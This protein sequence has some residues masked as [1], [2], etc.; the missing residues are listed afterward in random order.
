[1]SATAFLRSDQ[2][3][4]SIGRRIEQ[5][6][7]ERPGRAWWLALAASLGLVGVLVASL[8]WLLFEGVGVWNNNIPVTW[9]LDIVGYDWWIGIAT[10]ALSLSV[11]P[12]LL[13]RP[14]RGAI[15]RTS[16][17]V[18]VL[19]ALAAA[20]YPVVHLGRPWFFYWNLPY[21]NT[22]LLWP[23]F[24]SPLFWD[25]TDIL[26]YLAVS[27]SLWYVGLLP[28][29]AGLRDRAVDR[30]NDDT[31]G[32][33]ARSRSPARSGTTPCCRWNSWRCPASPAWRCARWFCW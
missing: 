25:A 32:R 31:G 22:M 3:F 20:T 2:T 19:A 17:T 18:S 7:L 29:L 33:F 9:A 14:W 6:A 5:G 13:R 11:V 8:G 21:P 12:V 27:V 16:E 15:A 28:D 4:E 30:L 24:R 1:M 10:G 23:Q 26:S